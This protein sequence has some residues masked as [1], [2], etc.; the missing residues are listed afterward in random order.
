M[1]KCLRCGKESFLF[2]NFELKDGEICKKC[3]RELGFGPNYDYSTEV[4]SYDE[5]KVGKDEMFRI[6]REKDRKFREN[7]LSVLLS[8][9][10]K[11]A[12]VKEITKG[13]GMKTGER[14]LNASEDELQIFDII[15]AMSK[16]FGRKPEDLRLVRPS[17][18]Y[19]SIKVDEY[20][21]ARFHLG[22]RSSWIFFPSVES[23]KG[24]HKIN[25]PED[26]LQFE[27]LVKE[28]INTIN[29]Y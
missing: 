12:L 3:F 21:L 29:S 27:N 22:E 20:D 19:V 28:S 5:I 6:Q 8:D 24:R 23:Y 18:N 2:K 13:T 16:V 1:G 14:E 10:Q 11:E 15:S 7:P 17:D 25:S 9:E 26:V 4:Y